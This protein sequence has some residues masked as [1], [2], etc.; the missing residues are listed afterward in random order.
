M[1]GRVKE[2]LVPG[3]CGLLILLGAGLFLADARMKAEATG[4]TMIGRVAFH[5][6]NA[7]RR[8]KQ[9]AVF[10]GLATEQPVFNGDIVRTS[11]QTTATFILNDGTRVELGELSMAALH[12]SVKETA[13]RMDY[14][15]VRSQTAGNR[16]L[17]LVVGD[18]A[19]LSRQGVV[20]AAQAKG[21]DNARMAVENGIA[22]LEG[23]GRMIELAS[24][25]QVQLGPTGVTQSAMAVLAL[26]PAPGATLNATGEGR[27][28]TF[29]W[30]GVDRVH[31]TI[32]RAG[33]TAPIH[34][35]TRA[36]TSFQTTLPPGIYSW[37]VQ[38]AGSAPGP[39]TQARSLLIRAAHAPDL[40]EPREGANL[41]TPERETAVLFR[42]RPIAF[43]KSYVSEVSR[44][45]DLR[46][47]LLREEHTS[48]QGIRKL[49]PGTYYWRVSSK[50]LDGSEI[51][52]SRVGSFT[53]TRLDHL[54]APVLRSPRTGTVESRAGAD[55][56]GVLFTWSS[57][58]A[59]NSELDVSQDEGFRK[60]VAAAKTT[61]GNSSLLKIR[62]QAGTYFWRVRTRLPDGRFTP[63]SAVAVLVLNE[64]LDNVRLRL[65]LPDATFA[66]RTKVRFAWEG[67][68]STA[69]FRLS[70]ATDPECKRVVRLVPTSFRSATVADLAPGTY[71]WRIAE[72]NGGRA[73]GRGRAFQITQR[74]PGPTLL[75]PRPGSVVDMSAADALRFR[76]ASVPGAKRYRVVLKNPSGHT[77]GQTMLA[78]TEHSFTDMARL[79]VGRFSVEVTAFSAGGA[80]GDPGRSTFRITLGRTPSAPKFADSGTRFIPQGA[81]Q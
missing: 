50:T 23:R 74:L 78:G 60:I 13:V 29:R 73:G 12:L 59:G 36:G 66:A 58:I 15:T 1:N 79:D 39:G 4:T 71:Y 31:L 40:I 61:G 70:I 14:G 42:W 46:T 34:A 48:A 11:H 24:G 72:R 6:G 26:E 57:A 2:A 52:D 67:G 37:S 16:Q 54:P 41:Q 76:W 65:P 68:A 3:G 75:E 47:G 53:V 80:S 9:G 56:Q 5:Q 22:R 30:R 25:R 20:S 32:K 62:A 69:R 21:S 18:R 28:V 63:H 81:K 35:G 77:L 45:A 27:S 55:K 51:P 38:E 7:Q 43:A 49:K 8:A 17:R 44:S 10:H 33:A 19:L 64:G